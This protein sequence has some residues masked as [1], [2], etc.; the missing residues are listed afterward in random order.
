[1]APINGDTPVN[2][3]T[4]V[5]G[6][7]H[8]RPSRLYDLPSQEPNIDHLISLCSNT[9]SKSDYPHSKAVVSNIPI[10]D[11]TSF[12]SNDATQVNAL[13]DEWYHLLHYGPGVFVLKHFYTDLILIDHV[14]KVFD[15]IIASEAS[16]ARGDHFAASGK[17]SRI[18]NS[19]QKHAE[20]DPS[21]FVQYY[22]NPWLSHVSEAWLGPAYQITA[23]VNIVKPGGA[24]QMPHRDYHLGF[25]TAEACSRW[26]KSVHHTSQFLT[27]QGAV[28]HT[29]M[30]LESGPTRFLPFS[31]ML[32]DGYMLWRTDAVKDYFH[33]NWVSAPLEK[34]DGV[35]FNPALFHAAGE[36]Q[37]APGPG[38]IDRSAN[39]LQ[40]SSAFGKTMETINTAKTIEKCWAELRRKADK[41]GVTSQ[42]VVCCV[43]AMS[44]GYPFPSNL[45][46]RPPAPG[47]MAPESETEMVLRALKEKWSKEQVLASLSQMRTD[48]SA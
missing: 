9:T 28:A 16:H 4:S 20:H 6:H 10:Y 37:T 47:G 22:S 46:N 36:N 44:L 35:F 23:Q 3:H 12:S 25:Q 5:N 7:I 24:P 45:D 41:A 15:F 17:N 34:G 11:L 32:E 43:Q 40:I 39:L 2:G 8:G 31:Q 26:P 42:E 14:N 48:S 19:F 18:W 27:L 13:Q 38:G 21:S 30:P 1:M 29:D 33:A